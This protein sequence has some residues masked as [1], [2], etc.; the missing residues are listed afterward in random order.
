[1]VLAISCLAAV[2]V[3]QADDSHL[4]AFES[5]VKRIGVLEHV[6]I[7]MD[8]G[9]TVPKPSTPRVKQG[10]WS[11]INLA[12]FS[13]REWIQTEGV[14]L[15]VRRQR[16]HETPLLDQQLAVAQILDSLGDDGLRAAMGDGVSLASL[17]P[18]DLS[19][20]ISMAFNWSGVTQSSSSDE[21]HATFEAIKNR[22]SNTS[23]RIR[24]LSK[25]VTVDEA[26]NKRTVY[27]T[28]GLVETQ[29]QTSTYI[30]P[31][32]TA[33]FKMALQ[34]ALDDGDLDFGEGRLL[35]V[36]EL[37]E[38]AREEF[39]VRYHVDSRVL[40]EILFVSGRYTKSRF[41]S[42]AKIVLHLQPFQELSVSSQPEQFLSEFA[43][44]LSRIKSDFYGDADQ[45]ISM[46]E[47]ESLDPTAYSQLIAHGIDPSSTQLVRQQGLMIYIDPGVK[48]LIGVEDRI[49][50]GKRVRVTKSRKLSLGFGY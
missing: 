7:F 38:I 14:Q 13:D 48:Q 10:V 9:K 31:E 33:E 20:L 40:D 12:A 23:L 47:M 39:K 45:R 15:F 18:T 17:P 41:E 30:E 37:L 22:V 16:E 50:D 3:L 29:K 19:K 28:K 6:S 34:F 24:P 8:V 35:S 1:M 4:K 32:R 11:M 21:P 49:I 2:F 5:E 42:C 25:F 44:K 26:G 46:Q 43:R 36:E 27:D